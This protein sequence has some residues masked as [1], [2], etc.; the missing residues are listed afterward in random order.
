DDSLIG[1]NMPLVKVDGKQVV[2][3]EK[4]PSEFTSSSKGG[5]VFNPDFLK[6]MN[7]DRLS[8]LSVLIPRKNNG[9][10]G[11]LGFGKASSSGSTLDAKPGGK[12]S[13]PGGLNASDTNISWKHTNGQ[14]IVGYRVYYSSDKDGSYSSIGHTTATDYKLPNKLGYYH[15]RAVNYFGEE[16]A[17]SASI[18]I[19]TDKASDDDSDEE[20][21]ESEEE[22]DENKEE[23]DEKEKEKDKDKRSEERRV[24]K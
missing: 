23:K 9:N 18:I 24:G 21:D 11:K 8:D 12:L 20:K 19:D 6:R 2:A 17:P 10:W 5:I 3:H 1:G 14:L 4:T 15:V 7:Y 16:S 13:A 22:E